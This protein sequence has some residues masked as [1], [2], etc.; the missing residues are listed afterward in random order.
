MSDWMKFWEKTPET[1]EEK[2]KIK[3]KEHGVFLN[4]CLS[5]DIEGFSCF[6]KHNLLNNLLKEE[7][8]DLQELKTEKSE[9]LK[10]EFE[11]KTRQN[12][13]YIRTCM[14]KARNPYEISECEIEYY[15]LDYELKKWKKEMDEKRPT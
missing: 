4:N 2:F 14:L 6:K 10:E 8:K 1:L 3:E 15:K 7:L 13:V 5:N 9:K 12:D 11:N